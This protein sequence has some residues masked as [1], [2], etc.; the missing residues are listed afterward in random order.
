MIIRLIQLLLLSAGIVWA[1]TMSGKHLDQMQIPGFLVALAISWWLTPEIRAR[2]LKLGLVD[3]PGEDRRIHKVAV[4]R[5]GGVAIYI[6][7]IVTLTLMLAIGGRFPREGG[8]AG[9]AVGGTLIFVLGLLDDLES[10]SAKVKLVVQILAGCAAYSL[11][12]RIKFLPMPMTTDLDLGF[13]HLHGGVP[14]DLGPW[15]LPLTVLW[16]VGVANAVNLIDGMD[17]LAAG[18]S[19]ISAISIWS[20]AMAINIGQPY[21]ALIA[22]VLAGALLGFLRWNFNPARIFLGDSGAYLT[23]FILGAVSITGV[24]K[25]VTA[26]TLIVP[27]FVLVFLI[28][29]FPL[30]D[31][32]WAIVRRLSTGRS[33]FAPDAGHIHHRLL[34][35]GLS[36]KTVAYLIYGL[37]GALGLV[38]AH[39]VNQ[40][41]YLLTLG[42]AVLGMALFF[43]EVLNRHRQKRTRFRRAGAYAEPA[44]DSAGSGSNGS[45]DES[46]RSQASRENGNPDKDKSGLGLGNQD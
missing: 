12:V 10:L 46:G 28:L 11:G 9:I 19:L 4:P 20:V 16:L 39:L 14:I 37:T 42:A 30:I 22:A 8:L 24:V 25:G 32:A 44:S 6:S 3:Q 43:A 38:A 27:T 31:T 29:F 7:L 15:A 33:I 2:A 36:Q 41:R 13:L 21:P 35:A 45:L 40:E 17:G 26:V 1:F 5:L 34:Q 18:V 23:G